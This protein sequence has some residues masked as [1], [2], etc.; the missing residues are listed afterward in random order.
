MRTLRTSEGGG[1]RSW[2]A[3]GWGGMDQPN[4]KITDDS[5]LNGVGGRHSEQAGEAN[6]VWCPHW[7]Q[8]AQEPV[9]PFPGNRLKPRSQDFYSEVEG[10]EVALLKCI[11]PSNLLAVGEL[12]VFLFPTDL[13]LPSL[14]VA[15]PGASKTSFWGATLHF[16]SC[17]SLL[18]SILTAF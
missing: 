13:I 9:R 14:L 12:N 11:L 1:G 10:A 2:Q 8:G 16:L 18:H 4:P 17:L 7:D 6:S 5:H 15:A 3:R